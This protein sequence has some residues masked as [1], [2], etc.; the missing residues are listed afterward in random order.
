M[1][2][3]KGGVFSCVIGCEEDSLETEFTIAERIDSGTMYRFKYRSYNING[4]SDWS[5][6]SYLTAATI[7]A[8]P[9]APTFDDATDTTI[10]LSFSPSTDDKGSEITEYELFINGGGSSANFEKVITYDGSSLT[11]TLTVGVDKRPDTTT[12]AI[13]P[14][15]IYKFQY[16]AR[17]NYGPS[18]FSDEVEAGVSA[19]P[20]APAAPTKIA[21]DSG[22]TFI[23]LQWAS[24]ADPLLPV[25]GYV[26]NIDDGFGGDKKVI[27]DGSNQP[28][29]LQYTASGL[30]T[31]L[32]YT[33]TV[34]AVNYNGLGAESP[35]AEFIICV[36]PVNFDPP[37]LISSTKTTLTL[38]WKAPSSN[39][40]C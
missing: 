36:A 20:T 9:P 30:I 31:G 22:T 33:F 8:R 6:I 5:P 17:N 15:T 1:D 26:L 28:N 4:A 34:Q 35:E 14:G 32:S 39:G 18:D 16:R 37:Y 11:H 2:N 12:D 38:G 23:T 24:V 13:A 19:F 25:I 3:G 21:A 40:G 10:V 27:Y 29:V 7:P